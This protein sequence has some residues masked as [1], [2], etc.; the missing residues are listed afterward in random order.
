M[1]KARKFILPHHDPEHRQLFLEFIKQVSPEADAVSVMLFGQ[2]LMAGNQLVQA[3]EKNLE[4]VG[5]TWAKFRL[6]MNL[7]RGEKHGTPC[8]QPSELSEMQGISRNTVSALISS[9]EKDELLSRELHGTDRR[10]FLIHLTPKG[11]KMLKAELGNQFEFVSHCFDA[12]NAKERQ[13]LQE[14]LSRLNYSLIGKMK[15]E[16]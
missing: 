15:S 10:K 12:L 2:L 14:Y 1:K 4:A 9:L 7:M 16:Q 8:M 13:T 3:A 11:R 6:L 5:L